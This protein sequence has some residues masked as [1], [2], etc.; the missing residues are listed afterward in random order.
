MQN[1]SPHQCE[2]AAMTLQRENVDITADGLAQL[3]ANAR[4]PEQEPDESLLTKKEVC[5]LT[6]MSLSTVDRRMKSGALE[7]HKDEGLVRFKKSTVLEYIAK[8]TVKAK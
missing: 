1:V 2:I 7:Y 4:K 5:A 8:K 6:N 3:L